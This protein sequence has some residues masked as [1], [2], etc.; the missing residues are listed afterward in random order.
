MR[1]HTRLLLSY[2]ILITVTLG[3]IVVTLL[4]F[5]STR[6]APLQPTYQILTRG[7]QSSI[8]AI[9]R[10]GRPGLLLRGLSPETIIE[11]LT[12]LSAE[13]DIRTLMVQQTDPPLVLFDSSGIY[14]PGDSIDTRI[15]QRNVQGIPPPPGQGGPRME[16]AI[17]AFDDPDGETWLFISLNYQ[18]QQND[19]EA[20]VYAL[21]QPTQSLREALGEFSNALG[22]PIL[23][24]AFM[25]IVVAIFMAVLV[26]RT[27]AR[28]LLH[29]ADAALAVA[30]G[31][32]DR[33]VPVTGPPEV[34]TVAEAFK[35]HD[36][37]GAGCPANPA[38]FYGQRLARSEN[39]VDLDSGLLAGYH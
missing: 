6:P 12:T 13:T 39:P 37:P 2:L 29:I 38:R 1:L 14:A 11:Q 20:I 28:P 8:R 36:P 22:V 15:N 3:V 31:N 34:R 21:P 16:T 30:D 5:L 24:A 23:Q 19:P 10:E 26:S 33:Q 27:I 18:R 35:S 4:V 7:A 9:F 25:G 32:Y 17:G